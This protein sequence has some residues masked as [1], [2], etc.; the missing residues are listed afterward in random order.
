MSTAGGI[1][2][3][4]A[5]IVAQPL[6]Q[7]LGQQVIVDNRPGADGAIAG[8]TGMK[9]APDGYTLLFSANS[10]LSAVPALRKNPRYHPVTDFTPIS[11]VGR[12]VFFVY[13]H[14]GVPANTLAEFASCARA[15]PGK[16]NYGT[17]IPPAFSPRRS[18]HLPD[19]PTMVEAGFPKFAVTPWAGMFGPAKLPRPVVERLTREINAILQRP[20]IREQIER[21]AFCRGRSGA[22]RLRPATGRISCTGTHSRRRELAQ[23]FGRMIGSRRTR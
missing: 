5:R 10:T 16:L 15:N 1:A 8:E 17:P 23:E 18:S 3:A 20:E 14:P 6:S 2:D 22:D 9:A 7:A 19:V 11:M 4:V 13:T 12:F 21:Q